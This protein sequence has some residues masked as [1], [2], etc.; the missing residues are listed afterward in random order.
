MCIASI[1]VCRRREKTNSHIKN[2]N[3]DDAA[4]HGAM[5]IASENGTSMHNDRRSSDD[6]P[7][8]DIIPNVR[9]MHFDDRFINYFK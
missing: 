6:D 2:P 3:H 7:D 4:Y 5:L 1:V 9:G 8:P